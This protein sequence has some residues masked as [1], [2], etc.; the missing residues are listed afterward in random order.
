[1]VVGEPAVV[2]GYAMAGATVMPAEGPAE[3][4]R[5]W[6]GL[7]PDTT[8]VI[9]TTAAAAHLMDELRCAGTL[10]AVMPG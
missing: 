4:R 6:E 1:M 2:A 7:T 8:L 9:L 5:A 3:V 10:V